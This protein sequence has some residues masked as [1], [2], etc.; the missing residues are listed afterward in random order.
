MKV[1]I[2]YSIADIH[3]VMYIEFQFTFYK[4][5]L[6]PKYGILKLPTFDVGYTLD[7]KYTY[8]LT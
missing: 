5:S 7:S 3:S 8:A 6:G 2:Y 1:S 4:P